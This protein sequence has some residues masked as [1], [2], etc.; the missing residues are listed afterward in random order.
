MPHRLRPFLRVAAVLVALAIGGGAA[1]GWAEVRDQSPTAHD[2]A[3]AQAYDTLW[4]LLRLNDLLDIMQVEGAT[5][6]LESDVDLLG[7]PGGTA[8]ERRVQAIYDIDR[9]KADAESAME[10]AL[11]PAHLEA[12]NSFYASENMQRVVELEISARRAFLEPEVEDRARTAWLSGRALTPHEDAIL[13]FVEVNDLVERNVMGA[14][15]SNYAFLRA[16]TDAH[17]V[18]AEKLTEQEIL[19]EVW[20]QETE[21]RRD[22]S[23]W[24]FAFLSTAYGPVSQ[25]VLDDYV[26]F[27][28]TPAGHALNHAMFEALDQIY[29]R[30]SSDLGRAV[31]EFGAQQDL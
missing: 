23:E 1:E 31:G 7:H 5:M 25:K 20:S 2:T 19:F 16:M 8:W 6:A 24:L 28:A 17:P 11:D 29:I 21:I 9:L 22:T 27:S 3:Q 26:S 4:S 14:L 15:N 10:A 18:A 13:R 12:L 30:L